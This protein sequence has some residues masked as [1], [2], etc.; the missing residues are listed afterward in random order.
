VDASVTQAFANLSTIQIRQ[1]QIQ[2]DDLKFTLGT[3]CYG[4]QSASGYFYNI[5]FRLQSSLDKIDNTL[6][7]FY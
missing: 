5:A 7:V 3:Q 1:T 2:N 4:F 6:I